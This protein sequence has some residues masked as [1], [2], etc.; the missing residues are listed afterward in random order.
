MDRF[1]VSVHV[2]HY[3]ECLGKRGV[4][5]QT[6]EHRGSFYPQTLFVPL[7]CRTKGALNLG[8]RVF[9]RHFGFVEKGPGFYRVHSSEEHGSKFRGMDPALQSNF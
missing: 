1:F 2:F 6:L 3:A 5:T 4:L 9:L 7:I 8:N